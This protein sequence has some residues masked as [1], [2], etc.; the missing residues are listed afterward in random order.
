MLLVL[1]DDH[2]KSVQWLDMLVLLVNILHQGRTQGSKMNRLV[3][4]H[5]HRKKERMQH[6]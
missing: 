1:V 5:S 4:L 3:P 6:F 2:I